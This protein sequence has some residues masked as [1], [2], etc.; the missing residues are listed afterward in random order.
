M[1]SKRITQT[2]T[3]EALEVYESMSD[4]MTGLSAALLA[5]KYLDIPGDVYKALIM[6]DV[7]ALKKMSKDGEL[8]GTIKNTSGKRGRPKKEDSFAQDETPSITSKP[9]TTVSPIKETTIQETPKREVPK[10]QP[11]ET[12]PSKIEEEDDD[13][14]AELNAITSTQIIEEDDEFCDFDPL[15]QL[16]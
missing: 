9:K 3:D 14:F 16:N 6:G 13:I 11:V 1:A 12:K 2:V 7:A 10:L 5:F 8:K 4:K 15:S